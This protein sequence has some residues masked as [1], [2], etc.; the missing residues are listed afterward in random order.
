[1]AYRCTRKNQLR[2]TVRDRRPEY[3]RPYSAEYLHACGCPVTRMMDGPLREFVD[4]SY[5]AYIEAE[6]AKA[7]KAIKHD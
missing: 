6:L 7:R 3:T 1:M 2:P 5:V 4:A